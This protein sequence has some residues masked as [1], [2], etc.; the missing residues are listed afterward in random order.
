MWFDWILTQVDWPHTIDLD[1]VDWNT[2][3]AVAEVALLVHILIDI[4]RNRADMR[5]RQRS[6]RLQFYAYFWNRFDRLLDAFPLRVFE[7]DFTLD[8]AEDEETLMV[9]MRSYFNLCAQEYFMYRQGVIEEE[10][11]HNWEVGL[12]HCMSLPA[13]REAYFK[14]NAMSAYREFHDWLSTKVDLS[15]PAPGNPDVTE[16]I[17]EA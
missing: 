2:L 12:I 4:K 3:V 10:I 14:L 17:P 15:E 5:Q 7:Q 13:F 8:E 9:N 16:S 11:W 6:E 1:P